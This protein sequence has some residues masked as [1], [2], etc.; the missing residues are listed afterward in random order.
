M[1]EQSQL[2]LALVILFTAFIVFGNIDGRKRVEAAVLQ[3]RQA[4]EKNGGQLVSV[5]KTSSAALLKGRT[6][7][8]VENFSVMVGVVPRVNPI[9]YLVAKAAGRK[10]LIMFR[11]ALR[12]TPRRNIALIRA[13]S[14]AS[15]YARR[16]G[17]QIGEIQG[18]LVCG[19]GPLPPLDNGLIDE[20]KGSGVQLVA[21]RTEL[22]HVYAYIDLKGNLTTATKAVLEA[23]EALA[24]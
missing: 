8:G 2:F 3:V 4:L 12:K 21:V 14:H 13:G 19:D 23:V 20:L 6:L 9:T 15:R 17:S 11:G 10:D 7:G 16:W 5:R 22:P 1:I 24:A 18:Y